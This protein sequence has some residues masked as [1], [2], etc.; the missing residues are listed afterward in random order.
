LPAALAA[1]VVAEGRQ[2]KEVPM[3]E[4]DRKTTA[5]SDKRRPK[6]WGGEGMTLEEEMRSLQEWRDGLT[7]A[8]LEKL[9]AEANKAIL[10]SRKSRLAREKAE[11][12][13]QS[14]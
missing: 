8:E 4:P 12:K 9:D 1:S 6:G 2:E 10:R 14:A 7:P 11:A 3:A 13:K 5:R